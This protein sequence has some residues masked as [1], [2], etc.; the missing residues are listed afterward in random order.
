M[1]RLMGLTAQFEGAGRFAAANLNTDQAGLSF[2]LIQWAQKPGRLAELL[3][4]FSKQAPTEFV[5]ILGAGD[6]ALAQGLIVH[7]SLPRG[8]TDGTGATTDPDFNLLTDPWITRFRQAALD[9]ALQR[10]QV[11]A[12]TDAFDISAQQVRTSAPALAASERAMAFMLDLANQHGDG[13]A[14]SIYTAAGAAPAA[15]ADKLQAM[16]DESV[17]RVAAQFGAASAEAMSTRNRR[18]AFRTSPLF[19]D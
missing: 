14:R 7:T 6:P 2:G 4:A 15:I 9:R 17:H 12:A 10:A 18:E 3:R 8:G 1:T 5:R 19:T 11:Q 16:A 13:G